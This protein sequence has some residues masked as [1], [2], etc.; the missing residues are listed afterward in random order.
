MSNTPRITELTAEADRALARARSICA[1][2]GYE[3]EYAAYRA[4]DAG[5][6]LP[7]AVVAALDG[8]LSANH[9][10]YSARDGDPGFLG[11]RGL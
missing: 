3:N 1:S 6:T 5:E 9:A 4:E 11:S 10:F 7:P 8:Y 2:H